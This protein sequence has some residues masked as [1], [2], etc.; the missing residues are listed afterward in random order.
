VRAV[1][2]VALSGEFRPR[3]RAFNETCFHLAV[4]IA[5]EQDTLRCLRAV[6]GERLS[7]R[8]SHLEELGSWVDMM[9]RE[10]EGAAVISAQC[11]APAGLLDQDA[12]DF[13]M[14][15]SDCLRDTP[16]TP[17]SLAVFGE[18]SGAMLRTLPRIDRADPA[19]RRWPTGAFDE[20]SVRRHEQMFA[21]LPDDLLALSGPPGNR[22]RI[23][24]LKR[25][26]RYR[27]ASGPAP[28]IEAGPGAFAP[29][30]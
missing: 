10:G 12:A 5:A 20:W 4:A 6:R 28:S 16:F 24:E 15:S 14:P 9:E 17:P 13:L 29:M 26:V 11:A 8:H 3:R 25:L 7:G 30:V 23:S 2:S 18:F 22:T 27:Y 1:S 19:R 21:P